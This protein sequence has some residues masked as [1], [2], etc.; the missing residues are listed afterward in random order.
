MV[1]RGVARPGSGIRGVTQSALTRRGLLGLAASVGRGGP[2]AATRVRRLL[3]DREIRADPVGQDHEPRRVGSSRSECV[4]GTAQPG[5]LR[6]SVPRRPDREGLAAGV[7]S[8]HRLHRLRACRPA[9]AGRRAAQVHLF[10]RRA[11]RERAFDRRHRH[12]RPAA[13]LLPEQRSARPGHVH[14]PERPRIDRRH[15]HLGQRRP[16]GSRRTTATICPR[17]T[18]CS[19]RPH[20]PI[21]PAAGSTSP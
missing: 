2:G 1:I 14:H 6:D 13:V 8:A 18:T 16:P 4:R 19:T 11:R 17:A 3:G 7:R 9:G 10:A 15:R 5:A 12:D 21:F 20:R